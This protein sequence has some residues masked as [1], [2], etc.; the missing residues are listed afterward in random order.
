MPDLAHAQPRKSGDSQ[1]AGFDEQLWPVNCTIIVLAGV[2]VGIVCA[3]GNFDSSESS[4]LA[5]GYVHL[6]ILGLL[7]GTLL[8]AVTWLQGRMARRVQ[9]SILFS[10]LVHLGLAVYL[11]GQYLS[12]F[13]VDEAAETLEMARHDEWITV[14]DY[15]WHHPDRPRSIESFQRPAQT[16]TPETP[17]TPLPTPTKQH[18]TEEQPSLKRPAPLEPETDDPA[19]VDPA[20]LRRAEL[21]PPEREAAAEPIPHRDEHQRPEPDGVVEQPEIPE[22]EATPPP[23]IELESRPAVAERQLALPEAAREAPDPIPFEPQSAPPALARRP[24]P[25]RNDTPQVESPALEPASLV[26]A[27]AGA[28]L[29]SATVAVDDAALPSVLGGAAPSPIDLTSTTPVTKSDS[30]TLQRPNT[31]AIGAAEFALGSSQLVARMGQPRAVGESRPSIDPAVSPQRIARAAVGPPVV[32]TPA[33]EVALVPVVAGSM[34]GA[35]PPESMPDAQAAPLGRAGGVGIPTPPRASAAGSGPRTSPGMSGSLAPRR[36]ARV[37]GRPTM[38]AAR[39]GGGAPM[40]AR[41]F[42]R[43]VASDT[44]VEVPRLAPGPPE[45][46]ISAGPRLEAQASGQRRQ[47]VGL[48]GALDAQPR[49][50]AAEALTDNGARLPIAMARRAIPSQETPGR[51]GA[52]PANSATMRK[53]STGPR[54]PAALAPI[55]NAPVAGAGGVAVTQGAQPSSLQPGPNASLQPAG[56]AATL[57]RPQARLPL[58]IAG[59]GQGAGS[60]PGASPAPGMPSRR[61]RSEGEAVSSLARREVVKRSG[62][63]PVIDG[64]AAGMPTEAFRQRDPTRRSELSRQHGATETSERAVEMGLDFL[65]RQQFPDGHWSLHA[66]PQAGTLLPADAAPGQMR[67]DTAA[68]GLALLAFLGAGYTHVDNKHRA[69]VALG[70]DWLVANQ[71]PGGELFT[72]PTDAD[73][74]ARSYAHGMGAI[75]LSEAYGMTKDPKL[76]EPARRAIAFILDSQHPTLGGWRYT[77]KDDETTWNR[78]SDTSVSGWQLM[79]LKSA[80]MAGLEVPSRVMAGVDHWLD[81]AQVDA[82]SRYVYNPYAGDRSEQRAGRVPSLAMTAEGLLMRMYLGWNRRTPA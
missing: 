62:V 71:Q 58:R 52:S 49:S 14:P 57:R 77:K 67:A 1:A 60:T 36:L 37:V 26:R 78:E 6:G 34:G 81:L 45:G 48:P 65:A 43:A 80:Q 9:F 74:A 13:T 47:T 76:R 53:A 19:D 23:P 50:G 82:G 44:T 70:L 7:I 32:S 54:L 73:R 69:V 55:A 35:G 21:T 2:F 63:A 38:P 68:T 22:T 8:W 31:A 16:P 28:N 3:Q 29:P 25:S 56:G 39:S 42:G 24:L 61:V 18:P 5:S 17:E 66:F 33:P 41:Q 75:A 79:A 27:D 12:Y 11:H 15:P 59:A 72:L 64:R 10:L 20:E 4:F 46:G 51:L 40:P 30:L